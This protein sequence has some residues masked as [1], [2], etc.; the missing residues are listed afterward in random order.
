M[1]VRCFEPCQSTATVLQLSEGWQCQQRALK[2]KG[3]ILI[4]GFA[5]LVGVHM[6]VMLRDQ[7]SSSKSRRNSATSLCP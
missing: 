3:T 6:R 4:A 5:T 2:Y 1:P 7:A